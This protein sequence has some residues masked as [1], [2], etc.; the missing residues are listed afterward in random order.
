MVI[1]PIAAAAA[2]ALA[3]KAATR[4]AG[5]IIGAG[6][7]YVHPVYRNMTPSRAKTIDKLVAPTIK[8]K[9]TASEIS[10]EMSAAQKHIKE[11]SRV[12]GR[13][14]ARNPGYAEEPKYPGARGFHR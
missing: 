10:K 4:A 13:K 7:K 2:R 14:N 1:G 8:N 11:L 12:R 9:G 6:E 5:G 3:K